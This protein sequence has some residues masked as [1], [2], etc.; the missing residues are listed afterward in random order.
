MK[1]IFFFLYDEGIVKNNRLYL[2]VD[3]IFM[4]LCDVLLVK[5]KIK[6]EMFYNYNKKN[7]LIRV[8]F[9]YNV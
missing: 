8:F 4:V 7:K 6:V 3:E 5:K 1:Y 9:L 2:N